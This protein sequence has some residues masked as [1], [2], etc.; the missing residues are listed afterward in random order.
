METQKALGWG[1]RERLLKI[2]AETVSPPGL[3]VKRGVVFTEH[4]Q[5]PNSWTE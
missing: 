1:A 2:T 5:L 3:P 4:R